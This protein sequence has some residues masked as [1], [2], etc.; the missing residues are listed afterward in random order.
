MR[1]KA[2]ARAALFSWSNTAR[3][4][5]EVYGKAVERFRKKS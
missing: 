5:R 2:L 3:L 4:T 1:E